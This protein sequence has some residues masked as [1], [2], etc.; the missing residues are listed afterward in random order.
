MNVDHGTTIS[1][2]ILAHVNNNR[3]NEISIDGYLNFKFVPI[4]SSSKNLVETYF[5][6]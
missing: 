5:S 3:I 4:I 1:K 6:R 2:D